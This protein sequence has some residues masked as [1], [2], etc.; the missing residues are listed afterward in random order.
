[1]VSKL[2][3]HIKEYQKVTQTL[4]ELANLRDLYLGEGGQRL[5]TVAYEIRT[6]N[7]NAP[8]LFNKMHT[9][10]HAL[11]EDTVLKRTSLQEENKKLQKYHASFEWL[12][13][14]GFGGIFITLLV[15]SFRQLIRLYR[16]LETQLKID[17]LTHLPNRFAFIAQSRICNV[18]L[19]SILN[20]NSFR[21]INELYGVDTGNEVLIR[22]SQFLGGYAKEHKLELFRISGDEFA[23]LC[24]KNSLHVKDFA[25]L[26]ENV[27]QKIRSH[28]FFIKS[29]DGQIKLSVSCGISANAQN[30]LGKADMALQRAKSS[31]E[32]VAIYNESL[33][34]QE[35]LKTHRYWI[36]KIEYAI[37]NDK[38]LPLYQPIVNSQG[39][40]MHYEAL[41]RLTTLSEEG[42]TIYHPPVYFLSLAHKTKCYPALS[43]MTLLKAFA[44]ASTEQIPVS[45]N[46]CYQDI[47]NLVLKDTLSLAITKMQIGT[48]ITF[49]IT[50]T[51]DIKNYYAII[52]FMKDFRSLG[53][54]LAIDDFGAGFSNFSY[55]P[56]L[57]PD[58]IKI[59]GSLVKEL[60]SSPYAVAMVHSIC[61]LCKE[62]G[63]STVAEF[64]HSKAVFLKAKELG[65]DYFQGYY[66]SPPILKPK[67][68]EFSFLPKDFNNE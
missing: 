47:L 10:V 40:A 66:F 52:D 21:T 45:V 19:S 9:L 46:L 41:M 25:T 17:P 2:P 32:C 38:F 6:I 61:T 35:L 57:K 24:C 53:V 39:I 54:R 11:I 59:D 51:E 29:I 36:E 27:C 65:V 5:T 43:K 1:M 4:F 60:D 18:P 26:M 55:I 30:P 28:S 64:I 34:S 62:L 3:I 50:E 22:L 68:R 15:L 8:K 58:I 31:H 12:A 48:L 23:F 14:F 44:L 7:A 67:T 49:E 56:K 33:D 13:L 37:E 42:T 20:I 16:Q 63:I